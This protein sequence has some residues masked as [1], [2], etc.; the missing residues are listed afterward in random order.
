VI[1]DGATALERGG[2]PAAILVQ[3]QAAVAVGQEAAEAEL[4]LIP[5][6]EFL[7]ADFGKQD[8]LVPDVGLAPGGAGGLA[9]HGGAGKSLLFINIGVAWSRGRGPFAGSDALRPSRPLRVGLFLVEDPAAETQRR[10]AAILGEDKPEGLLLF[11]RTQSITLGG[12]RGE[13]DQE[14]LAGLG[15]AIRRH[16][17]DVVILEPL[18]YLHLSEENQSTEMVRWLR[19]LCETCA[20]AGAA[21]ILGTHTGWAEDRPRG[22]TSFPAWCDFVLVLTKEKRPGGRELHTLRLQKANFAPP[23][24][25]DVSLVLDPRSYVFSVGDRTQ[26]LCAPAD[27]AAWVRDDL[28]GAWEGKVTDFY[29]AAAA[30]FECNLRTAGDAL[31]QAVAAKV[32]VR[33]GWGKAAS[34]RVP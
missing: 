25:Q 19:P 22:S 16:R 26:V 27:L 32:L 1:L 33:E 14:A 8:H 23:W 2:D 28:G 24:Q 6:S 29:E 3:L 7:A 31:R 20:E 5:A 13:P 11:P 21:V 17:L 18:V 4:P 9:G 12:L 15:R 10:L 34:I 30:R